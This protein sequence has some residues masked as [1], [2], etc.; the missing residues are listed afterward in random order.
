MIRLPYRFARFLSAPFRWLIGFFH[1][2]IH[3]DARWMSRLE[4]R[5]LMGPTRRGL[6]LSPRHR[7]P[8]SESFRNLGVVA[9]AGS[10]K[11][12]KYVIPNVLLAE[13][14]VV[15][16]TDMMREAREQEM[17]RRSPSRCREFLIRVFGKTPECLA[18]HRV[19]FC[20]HAV[21]RLNPCRLCRRRSRSAP[22]SRCKTWSDVQPEGSYR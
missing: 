8:R 21:S 16:L 10:G 3:A 17:R 15:A 1:S 2:T 14:S 7:L 12:S 20:F 4:M 9:P 11:T 19:L 6:V 22:S 18:R 5:R 13:G